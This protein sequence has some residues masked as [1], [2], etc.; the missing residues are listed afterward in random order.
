VA[1]SGR[2]IVVRARRWRRWLAALTFALGVHALLIVS[3]IVRE[4][5]PPTQIPAIAVELITLAPLPPDPKKREAPRHPLAALPE[6]PRSSPG[7]PPLDPPAAS[8]VARP[9]PATPNPVQPAPAPGPVPFYAGQPR[10]GQ[11]PCWETGLSRADRERCNRMG[12]ATADRFKIPQGGA[13]PGSTIDPEKRASLAASKD[14]FKVRVLGGELTGDHEHGDR[15][16]I[17]L[18]WRF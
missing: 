11:K 8:P 4:R 9:A 17:I 10:S 12:L 3:L 7:E 2:E 13:S 15:V 5:T 16:G 6:P 18:K 1:A 14:D